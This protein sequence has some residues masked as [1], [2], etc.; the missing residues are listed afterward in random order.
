M[1]QPD[2][3][4]EGI[5]IIGIAGRFPGAKSIDAFWENLR[6]G[7]EAVTP[8]TDEEV[9]A[10]GVDP[11][12]YKLPNYVKSGA[13][14]DDIDMFDATFFGYS[15]RDAEITDPQQ[16]LF[17]ECA[18]E[19]IENAGYNAESY[20]GL[21]GVFGGLDWSTYLAQIYA[22]LDKLGYVDGFQLNVGNDKDHLATQSSY[23]LN[24]RG[25]SITV[26]TACSTSLT[27]VCIAS[28]SLLSYNCDM[29]LAGGTAIAVP[30]RRG[31]YYMP[32]SILSPD[33]HCRAFDSAAQGTII[34]NGVGIVLLKRL[35]D[36]IADGD[37]V[38]AVIRGYGLNND[39]SAKVGYTAP[40]IEGQAQ[41][42]A[43]AQAMAGIDPETID[44]VEAHGTATILGDPIEVAA[45]TSVFRARTSKKN[46]CAIGS[47]KSNVGHLASAAG[48]AGLI[49]TVLSLEHRQ[50]PPTLHFTKP[51]PG[52]DFANS[53]FYVNATL[54]DWVVQGRKRRAAVSS[55]GVGGTNAHVILEEAPEQ[56]STPGS[57]TM[58]LLILSAKT[59]TALDKETDNAAEHLLHN[60]ELNL[61]DVAFTYQVGRKPFGYRRTLVFNG[62]DREGAAKALETRDPQAL[63]G[64]FSESRE[65]AILYMFS[66]QGS[67]YPNM[68]K[69]LYQ[70][71]RTFRDC[72]DHCCEI[73]KPYLGFDLRSVLY[74]ASGDD[75]A[76]DRLRN[77]AV[78]QPALF[79]VEYALAALW[80]EWGIMPSA[81]VGHSIGE[82]V[83]ACISGVMSPESALRL[84]AER[85]RLM[86]GMPPGAMLAVAM[87]EAEIQPLIGDGVSL[88]AVNGPSMCVLSGSLPVMD[89]VTQQLTGRNIQCRRLQTSH[90][91]HSSMMDAIVEEFIEAVRGVPL[92]A[93][94]IPYLS[95][96]TGNWAT[97][98]NATS[99]TYWGTHLRQ[100]VRFSDCMRRVLATSEWVL[101]ELGPGNTLC[102]L[103]RQQPNCG[104]GLLVV[105]STRPPHQN[106]SDSGVMLRALGQLWTS[107]VQVNWSG[108]WA[109]EKRRRVP[110]PTYPFERQRYWIGVPDRPQST[111]G[112]TGA[113]A[114]RSVDDWFY[115]PTWK[116]AIPSKHTRNGD[117]HA[118]KSSWLVFRDASRFGERLCERLSAIGMSV[119]SVISGDSFSKIDENTFTIRPAEKADYEALMKAVGVPKSLIIAHLWNVS[120]GDPSA[121]DMAAFRRTQE[122]GF[123]S[124][125]HLA[126]AFAKLNIAQS[127]HVGVFSTHLQIVLGD[128]RIDPAKA[129]Y[130]GACKVASQEYP[131]LRFRSVDLSMEDSGNED[132]WI[133][134]IIGEL[135]L[136]PFEATVAYRRG[137]RWV[138]RFDQLEQPAPSG[139]TRFRQEGVYLI[140]GGLGNIGLTLAD[141]LAKT[142]KA[143]LVLVG[144][145]AFPARDEWERVLEQQ[146]AG[147][148]SRKIR[149]LLE[150]EESG[151][152]VLICTADSSSL[153][154]M[155]SVF[156]RATERFGA[157]HGVVHGAGNV[158]AGAFSAVKDTT[159]ELA[160][161]Q[162]APKVEG[163]MVLAELCEHRDL[164]FC[165][166]LSSLSAV[167]GG[168]GLIAYGAANLFMDSFAAHQNQAEKFPWITVNWDAWHFP[169]AGAADPA[170]D[171]IQPGEGVEAFRRIVEGQQ[172]QVVVSTTDLKARYDKWI[173]LETIRG[174]AQASAPAG[175]LHTRPSLSSQYVAGRSDTERKTIEVWEQML[176]VSPVGVFDKFFELG[177]HSLLAIQLT[178]RLRE[179]FAIEFPVQR[180]FEFPT[181]A[182]LAESIDKEIAAAAESAAQPDE[183]T[184]AQ[185]LELVEQMSADELSALL[186]E[187]VEGK[188]KVHHG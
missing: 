128:E 84:V 74:P 127:I 37:N 41:A 133:D 47:L 68:C 134:R 59:S 53:P 43:M 48:V 126:Q 24:L 77:T 180:I 55:F 187:G 4:A 76:G 103:A 169:N 42:I 167:L 121:V 140:T 36:A 181:V 148:V 105:N 93:P 34:G 16:R 152:E 162:F 73:L 85:G 89:R 35:S 8:F 44:Y 153:D 54:K 143:K 159:R 18:W 107:G 183:Q 139:S 100:T 62:N 147:D 82:Y 124:L 39:G 163:L 28:Q 125:V 132:K 130:A 174:A 99:P 92:S 17:L 81:M 14:L 114:A 164:D 45:L 157:I 67:Q 117:H 33:G 46:Y 29:A 21:I 172:R 188:K 1:T 49:K 113:A 185:M 111:A 154:Q 118:A 75:Q 149:K 57:R 178:S 69:E 155:R 171:A 123:L 90:A 88:A 168:L 26:Q 94:K 176:G 98:E 20:P 135:T 161:G 64:G 78:T 11:S 119:V 182:Q 40:S 61:A 22:N 158:T 10:C 63:I 60:P 150:L 5:A 19:C 23:K 83:A 71:E 136:E 91:F 138:Q 120:S 108:F 160:D 129:T 146:A 102:T 156:D 131:Q 109:H 13:V 65:R 175:N 66:G 170:G 52:I 15:A 173:N 80:M 112:E 97:A 141:F 106:D 3:S 179:M 145:S 115:V 142:Y 56:K 58:Q 110:L 9:Q 50:M 25:P 104:P 96:V 151:A 31:Y 165:L 32:G 186:N 87:T 12:I 38:R 144:R 166:L 79:V 51:N 95:N 6:E 7:R 70:G 101:L 30:Q 137:R 122:T 27:A 86:A 2:Y 177:G 72:V 116:P 184:L